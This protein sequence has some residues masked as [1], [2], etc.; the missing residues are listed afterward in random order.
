MKNY[1]F[2]FTC[3]VLILIT[4]AVGTYMNMKT[5]EPKNLN[6]VFPKTSSTENQ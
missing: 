3:L 1:D 5:K 6:K 2:G 4:C